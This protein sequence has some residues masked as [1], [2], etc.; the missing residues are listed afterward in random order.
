MPK[1]FFTADWHLGDARAMELDKRP[2]ASLE[3][4]DR[5]FIRRWNAKVNENDRV[6]ILGDFSMYSDRKTTELV[7]QLKGHKHF[8][9]GNHDRLSEKTLAAL[10]KTAESYEEIN[11]DGQHV[12]LCHY[13][14]AHW[15]GQRYGYVHLYGHTHCGED[16]AFFEQYR[17]WCREQ[18][19]RFYAYNVG[20]MFH[21]YEPVTLKEMMEQQAVRE[22]AEDITEEI[23]EGEYTDESGKD[24]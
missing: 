13:P 15:R 14:I 10:F 16:A 6:Y 1:T 9:R 5:E 11:L 19:I 7:A 17:K 22:A 24:E 3:E 20:C 18:G 2:F 12:V 21:N 23:V 4:Q 8:I